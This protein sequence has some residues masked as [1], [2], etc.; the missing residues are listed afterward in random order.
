MAATHPDASVGPG[1]LQKTPSAMNGRFTSHQTDD[2]LG[3][4]RSA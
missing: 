4:S 1:S 2:A 3:R